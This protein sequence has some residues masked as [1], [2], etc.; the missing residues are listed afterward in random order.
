MAIRMTRMANQ[1]ARL[2][3]MVSPKCAWLM[4]RFR[5]TPA[6]YPRLRTCIVALTVIFAALTFQGQEAQPQPS[7]TATLQ[8]FVRDSSGR[9]VAGATVCLEAKDAPL[10]AHTDSAGAYRFSGVGQGVYRL[11]AEMSGYA[12]RTVSSV[13]LGQ[14]ESRTIN[15][16]LESAKTPDLTGRPE[17]FDEPHFTVAGVTDT[18][19]LGGHGSDTIV[20][21][22]EALVQATV[23]L[24]EAPPGSSATASENAT[25]EKSLRE[26]VKQQPE[27]FDANQQLGRLLVAEGKAGEGIPY[28]ERASRLHPGDDE[29]AYE[30]ALARADSGDYGRARTDVR[31]LLT[32]QIKSGQEKA[33]P[34]HLLG[35]VDEKL[36]NPLEAVQEYQRAAELNPSESNLFDWGAELLMHHAVEPALEVFTKGNRLYPRSVRMLAGLGASWYVHGSYDQA[37]ERLCEASDLDPNDP[38]PY[39][40]MGKMQAVEPTPSA[41]IVEKLGRFVRLQP[42]NALANY[43]YA[44]SLWKRRTSAEEVADL[45]QVKSL[46]ENAIHLDPK[47]GPAY[48]QLGVLYSE[49]KDFSNAIAAYRQAIEATPRLE[50]AHFRLAEAYRHTG[51]AASAQTELQV[52]ARISKEKA[53]ETEHQRHEVQ[54]FVY[55]LRNASAPPQ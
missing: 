19:N 24:S 45:A 42:Q 9:P 34:H 18:T 41:A 28:L 13:V 15:L 35:E 43:Y 7:G 27:G 52:Y 16:T 38:S 36:G 55:E 29:N 44:V 40:L 23:S 3:S 31:A 32:L 48:L 49:R 33:E 53:E 4:G 51:D 26:A 54:Q 25:R 10:T 11:R 39:F 14:K 37:A 50:E 8:G 30:L 6:T 5:V 1:R 46:L 21:N 22:R 47:L 2:I 12:A 17:F 20:R